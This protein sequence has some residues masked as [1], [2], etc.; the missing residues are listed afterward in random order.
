M[1]SGATGGGG[2]GA[3]A[4]VGEG[5][6]SGVELERGAGIVVACGERWPL[7]VAEPLARKEVSR[8]GPARNV[9]NSVLVL[10]K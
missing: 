3:G 6:G 4:R 8:I 10:S 2:V 7:A 5:R 1:A 9:H